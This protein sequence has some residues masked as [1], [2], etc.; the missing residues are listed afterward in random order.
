LEPVIKYS[1]PEE[2]RQDSIKQAK[3]LI[4]VNDIVNQGLSYRVLKKYLADGTFLKSVTSVNPTGRSELLIIEATGLKKKKRIKKSTPNMHIAFECCDITGEQFEGFLITDLDWNPK[5]FVPA[6]DESR[7]IEFNYYARFTGEQKAELFSKYLWIKEMKQTC[8]HP[9][10]DYTNYSS[11]EEITVE[12]DVMH[13]GFNYPDGY[14]E[15][16]GYMFQFY[17]GVLP[18]SAIGCVIAHRILTASQGYPAAIV[19][20]EAVI[21]SNYG[22]TVTWKAWYE[23]SYLTTVAPSIECFRNDPAEREDWNGILMVEESTSSGT[24]NVKDIYDTDYGGD[25]WCYDED[26][27]VCILWTDWDASAS[28]HHVA[29]VAENSNPWPLAIHP[30]PDDF[31]SDWND[32]SRYP[33]SYLSWEDFI[34]EL[35]DPLYEGDGYTYTFSNSSGTAR[36]PSGFERDVYIRAGDMDYLIEGA[37]TFLNKD[38]IWWGCTQIIYRVGRATPPLYLYSFRMAHMTDGVNWEEGQFRCGNVFKGE[39]KMLTIPVSV[40]VDGNWKAGMFPGTES[41]PRYTT[42]FMRGVMVTEF[43]WEDE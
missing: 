30:A 23:C 43:K 34:A 32:E 31:P 19:A 15:A 37:E 42:G 33:P 20:G 36:F 13:L 1:G 11:T 40:D 28:N 41:S 10:N 8:T 24:G 5:W 35:V 7:S 25:G 2:K 17:R 29:F 16:G 6:N 27:G 14:E 18:P 3:K 12:Q 22:N 26:G 21:A 9:L 4:P 38:D 39:H